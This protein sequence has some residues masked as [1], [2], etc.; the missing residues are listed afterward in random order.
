MLALFREW[1]ACLE[2]SWQR[3]DPHSGQRH[4]RFYGC[5]LDT[6]IFTA[7]HRPQTVVAVAA[8]LSGKTSASCNRQAPAHPAREGMKPGSRSSRWEEPGIAQT[9]P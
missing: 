9:G 4:I 2:K 3:Q 5:L 6:W 8:A 7:R 1:I